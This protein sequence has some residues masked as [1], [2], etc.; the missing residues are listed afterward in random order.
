VT[1]RKVVNGYSREIK[2]IDRRVGS[3]EKFVVAQHE[4]NA[5]QKELHLQQQKM[6]EESR[7]EM[8]ELKTIL[9]VL[10]NQNERRAGADEALSKQA[11]KIGN[12]LKILVAVVG[13]VG[14]LFVAAAWAIHH[15]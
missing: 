1:S 4:F 3:I 15:L 7:S 12:S 6:N 13:L 5:Q 11:T 2:L 10:K 8:G 14:S 9:G